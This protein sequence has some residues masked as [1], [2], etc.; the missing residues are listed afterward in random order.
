MLAAV[1]LTL[2]AFGGGYLAGNRTGEAPGSASGD[3][4]EAIGLITEAFEKI[5]STAVDPPNESVLA[6]GAI[7]GMV[8][9]LRKADDPYALFYSPKDYRS[10]REL[11]TGRFSGIGV[12]L[13]KKERRLEIVSVLPESPEL[14]VGLQRGDVIEGEDG[15]G[16]ISAA[17]AVLVMAFL[18]AAMWIGFNAI[19][20]DAQGRISTQVNTIGG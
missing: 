13:K 18:G 14:L 9:E 11:T 16:V 12:W 10:F 17:I 8:R 1:A 3:A 5:R 20:N 19:F 15:E 4:G 7:R 2:A 6:R